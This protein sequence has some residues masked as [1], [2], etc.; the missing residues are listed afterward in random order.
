MVGDVR[1]SIAAWHKV[2]YVVVY[3]LVM[4]TC[5][6]ILDHY[7]VH[8]IYKYFI[9]ASGKGFITSPCILECL[10]L[11]SSLTDAI[12]GSATQVNT[13]RVNQKRYPFKTQDY[14]SF[15]KTCRKWKH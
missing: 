11:H 3:P 13:K 4:L 8:C 14:R 2:L 7:E 10:D 6:L 1:M 9:T 12:L 15:A 5:I